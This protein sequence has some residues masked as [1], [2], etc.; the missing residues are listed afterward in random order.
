MDGSW[1]SVFS[2][3]SK[4]LHG[5]PLINCHEGRSMQVENRKQAENLFLVETTPGLFFSFHEGWELMVSCAFDL[6]FKN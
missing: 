5:R 2:V 1:Q 6:F 3:W 4:S